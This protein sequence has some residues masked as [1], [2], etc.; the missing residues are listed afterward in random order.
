MI[1]RPLP[2]I[3]MLI[4]YW[5]SDEGMES[6][7]NV[8][9]DDTAE[10]NLEIDSIYRIAT[11]MVMM[12]EKSRSPT[13]GEFSRDSF[14]LNHRLR[15]L[16]QHRGLVCSCYEVFGKGRGKP[17]LPRK[18]FPGF[19][20]QSSYFTTTSSPGLRP[21]SISTFPSLSLRPVLT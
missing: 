20:P 12:F 1:L 16:S 2:R 7:L 13:A 6:S 5:K 3:P 8:F 18:G 15:D 11:G 17:L 14:Q 21:E 19:I 9:F 10:E 4:C